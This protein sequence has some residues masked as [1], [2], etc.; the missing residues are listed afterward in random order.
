MNSFKAFAFFFAFFCFLGVAQVTPA[1]AAEKTILAFGDSLTAGLGLPKEQ[2]FPAKLE[3]KLR[4]EGYNI[5]VINA[6]VSGETTAGGLRRLDWSLEENPDFVILAL[7]ANDMLRGLDPKEAQKNLDAML[8]T[9]QKRKIPVLLAGM[10]SFM[11]LGPLYGSKFNGIYEDL[12]DKYDTFYYPF[13]LEDVALEPELNQDDGIHP[14]AAGVDVMVE[15]IYPYV[16]ELV[17]GKRK[18]RLFG[19]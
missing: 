16:E 2:A 19:R 8:Q 3:Q 17:T 5:R 7:G 12:A 14:N 15:N 10:K 6:G 11:N 9:L 18:F 13:F 4:A 1:Q